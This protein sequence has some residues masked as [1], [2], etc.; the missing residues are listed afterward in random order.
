MGALS[1]EDDLS[2][3]GED[4]QF[5]DGLNKSQ[6]KAKFPHW[7]LFFFFFV[8]L[9]AWNDASYFFVHSLELLPSPLS[10]QAFILIALPALGLQLT[11][12]RPRDVS[13]SVIA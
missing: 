11:C 6:E 4:H 1:Q 7:T 5:L 9:S 10:S 12:G 13:T 8:Y 2:S 3:V